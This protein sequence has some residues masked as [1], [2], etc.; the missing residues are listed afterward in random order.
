ML[1]LNAARSVVNAAKTT[2]SQAVGGTLIGEDGAR[3]NG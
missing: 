3:G 1:L 2:L